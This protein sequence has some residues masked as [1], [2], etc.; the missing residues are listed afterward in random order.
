MPLWSSTTRIFGLLL[1][2]GCLL[3]PPASRDLVPLVHGK[4]DGER[5]PLPHPATDLNRSFMTFDHLFDYGQAQPGTSGFGGKER[6]EYFRQVA[7]GYSLPRV[8]DLQ[9]HQSVAGPRGEAQAAPFW[10]GAVGA[11]Y[12]VARTRKR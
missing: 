7:L 4:P 6:L 1:A 11:P 9:L 3:F 8:A 12:R 2:K 5:G 10:Q